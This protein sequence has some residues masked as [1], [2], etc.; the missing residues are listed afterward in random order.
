MKGSPMTTP[1]EP[2]V[3]VLLCDDHRILTDALSIMIGLEPGL[4]LVAAAVETGQAAVDRTLEFDPDVVLMD[5]ELI[6]EM[7]GLQATSRIRE[8]SPTTSVVIMSGFGRSDS[9]LIAAIE[10]GASGFLSKTEAAARILDAIRAAARGESLIEA[11]ELARALRRIAE[12]RRDR[13]G[14]KAR[15]NSLTVREREVLQSLA[16]GET[17]DDIASA[18]FISPNTVQTHNRNILGKLGVHSK[19][20]AVAVAAQ[21]GVLTM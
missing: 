10:A 12:D 8:L 5:I 21:A 17:N 2:A 20:Q 7:T 1:T 6:G 14:I 13:G 15:T 9:T 19:L 11:A 3:R 16:R 18:L 4:E